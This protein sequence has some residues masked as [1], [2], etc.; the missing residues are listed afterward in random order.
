MLKRKPIVS[1]SCLCSSL[2][3]LYV[4]F[5]PTV[6]IPFHRADGTDF[7]MA[8]ISWWGGDI[9][10]TIRKISPKWGRVL[11]INRLIGDEQLD[12]SSHLIEIKNGVRYFQ[13]FGGQKI[14]VGRDLNGKNL[15]NT[16]IHFRMTYL[17]GFILY[18]LD[19]HV[20][21]VKVTTVYVSDYDGVRINKP[22]NRL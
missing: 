13:D 8:T 4:T 3:H 14:Q 16:S 17:K 6:T 1:F 5:V 22:H 11:P 10:M 19:V 2:L 20:D 7:T 18:M 21:V 12:G 9:I 15:A